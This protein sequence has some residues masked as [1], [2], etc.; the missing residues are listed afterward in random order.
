[1]EYFNGFLES[2][3][4][5]PW[6]FYTYVTIIGLMIGS[7]LNVVIYR[8]PVMMERAFKDE[9][10]EYFHPDEPL[11]KRDRFNLMVPRSRC[12]NCGHHISAWENIPVIS[13]LILRGK[14][15]GC[16]QPISMRYPIVETFTGVMSLIVAI[17]FGPTYQVLGALILTWC[18]IALSGIDYDKMLLPDEIV[19]P[20]LWLG[21]LFNM[22]DKGFTGLENSVIGAVAGYMILWSIYWGFK[23]LTGK[24]GMG[25]GDFKLTACLGAWLG[26]QMLGTIILG[27]ALV[28]AILGIIIMIFQNK[29]KS[30]P[31]P[32]GPYIA[33][34]GFVTMLYGSE[35]NK[36]YL[37]LLLK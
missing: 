20:L 2:M 37:A 3:R 17:H 10:Q 22:C 12:P 33:I 23:L 11:E 15:H 6:L 29:G 18:L 4:L 8:L 9:Y 30:K 21:I 34:A 25:Y 7:F 36:W 32:F 14:C 16:G 5:M 35:I 19:L 27:S 13:Y 1:M 24:E 31:I 28:G 26:W